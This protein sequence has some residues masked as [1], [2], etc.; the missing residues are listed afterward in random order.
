MS[1]KL[2]PEELEKLQQEHATLTQANASLTEANAKLTADLADAN[3]LLKTSGK[4]TAKKLS[5]DELAAI[6]KQ[7]QTILASGESNSTKAAQILD[8][9]GIG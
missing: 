8:L 2:T 6:E 1:E 3:E 9:L 5:K 4:K 7:M